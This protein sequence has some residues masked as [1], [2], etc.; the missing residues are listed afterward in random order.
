[1]SALDRIETFDPDTKDLNAVIETPRGSRNKFKWIAK[2]E[3]FQLASV[4]P[5]GAV[6]PYDFGFLPSTLGD[7]GDPVDV[8]VLMEEPAA[9]GCLIPVRL[10]GV[11]EAE[12]T[13]KG[14]TER[15]DRLIAA[16]VKSHRF[17]KA[18]SLDD[19]GGNLAEELEHFFVSYNRIRGVEFKPLGKHGPSRALDRVREGMRDF[20]KKPA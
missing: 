11:I 14:K 15:N 3:V 9:V 16:A 10:L 12:Q 17:E 13:E 5:A 20:E 19:L 18:K 4:L 2:H 7:D 1:M 6:F 8:L